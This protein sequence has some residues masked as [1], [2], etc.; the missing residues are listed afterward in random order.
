MPKCSP[1]TD[2]EYHL[3]R[4][5]TERDV[6][7]RSDNALASDAHMR[8]SA[9]HLQRALLLQTVRSARVGNVHPLQSTASA[10]SAAVRL[11]IIQLPSMR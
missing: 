3:R 2:V 5:R 1:G 9:L 6:A 4:A 10:E 7:Y 11:P 8:L